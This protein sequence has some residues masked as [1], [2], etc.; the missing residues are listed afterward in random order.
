[1][2]AI[3]SGLMSVIAMIVKIVLFPILWPFKFLFNRLLGFSWSTPGWLQS[4]NGK[5]RASP[6]K[7]WSSLVT[8]VILI[9]GGYT[10][11]QWYQSIPEPAQVLAQITAPDVSANTEVVH[12][13]PLDIYFKYDYSKNSVIPDGQ[14]SVARIED[15]D[16]EITK[17]I[18]LFPNKAG[19]W[20]WLGDKHI[21]F[22]PKQDWPAAQTYKVTFDQSMFA[23]SVLMSELEY[24]FTTAE[25]FVRAEN[26]RLYKDPTKKSEQRLVATLSFSHPVDKESL[27][28]HLELQIKN[29]KNATASIERQTFEIN[30]G[31]NDREA[32]IKSAPIQLPESEKYAHLVLGKEVKAAA[33][34]AKF[35]SEI[36]KKILL[37][38]ASTFLKVSQANFRILRN[39]ENKPEQILTLQFT[40]SIS[41][42]EI[43]KKLEI[44]L[45][46]KS[47]KSWNI[48]RAER[49]NLSNTKLPLTL[50]EN[51]RDFSKFYNVKLDVPEN[52]SVYIKVNS[53]LLSTSDYKLTKNYQKVFRAPDYPRETKIM[54]EGSLMSLNGDQTLS[55]MARGHKA[56]K[57]SLGKLVDHQLNHLISQTGG[58]ISSP[59]FNNYLF[60]QNNIVSNY[61]QVIRLSP[62]H[63]KE[64]NYASLP[65]TP[66]LKKQ[67]M[68]VFFVKVEG[69]N[70]KHNYREYGTEDQRLIIVTDLGVIVKKTND[71][72][73]QNVF[74][75]SLSKG[76]PV[77]NA[78]VEVLGKNGLPV[79]SGHTNDSGMVEIHDLSKLSREKAP[80]VYVVSQGKDV[81][82]L[83]FDNGYRRINYSRF[84]ISGSR[85]TGNNNSRLT[86]FVFSDRGIYRPG[87]TVKLASIVKNRN[88]KNSEGIPLEFEIKDSRNKRV[89]KKKLKLNKEGFFDIE[90]KTEA[91][92]NTGNYFASVY[93]LTKRG[94]RDYRLGGVN[95]KVEEFQPDTL[96]IATEI[97]PKQSKGWLNQPALVG[98]VTLKNLFG[99]PAQD[100]KVHGTLELTPIS[101]G[102]PE[103]RAY[104]FIDPLR[105]D[106]AQL[107][108]VTE[109]LESQTTDADGLA[110][111]SMDISQYDKGTYRL[112][113]KAEG[114]EAGGGRS[115]IASSSALVS[116]LNK[117]VGYKTDGE[118]NYLKKDQ[119]RQLS[120]IG[121]N[122]QLEK[123]NLGEVTL[124][125]I[126][127]QPISTLVMANDGTYSYQSVIKDRLQDETRMALTAKGLDMHLYTEKA[128]Q[129]QLQ[130][131]S[132]QGELLTKVDYHV[133]AAGNMAGQLEKNAELTLKLD[134]RDYKAG[135]TIEMNIIAPYSGSGLITIESDKVHN[136]KWFKTSTN[137]TVETIKV[138]A[139][140]EGNAYV[141][142]TFVRSPDSKEVF[143]SPLSY[144]VKPF[145]IDRSAREVDITL[146][147]EPLV[148]PGSPMKIGYK[149]DKPSRIVVFAVDE[150]ILQVAKYQQPKP[151]DHFLTKLALQVNT[152][153]ILDLI[154]PEYR[155]LMEQAGIGGGAESMKLLGANLN[156]FS[157]TVDKPAVYW[158]GI[159]HADATE[160]T[161]TFNVPDTFSGNLKVMAVAVSDSAMGA[162]SKDSIVR[163]PFVLSPNVLTVAAPN[164]AFDVVVGV[165]NGIEGSGDNADIKVSVK[166]SD[167]LSVVG[168][169]K[170][171][172]IIG[173]G[174]EKKARFKLI[175]KSDQ[176]GS[177]LGE[178]KV[179]FI[180]QHKNEISERS[181]TLSLRPAS[182]YATRVKTGYSEDKVELNLNPTLYSAFS[183]KTATA[184]ASPMVLTQ[185]LTE[186]L[187]NYIHGCTEQVVSKVFPWVTLSQERPEQQTETREKLNALFDKL[188]SRQTSD[189]GFGY[190]QNGRSYAFPTLYAAHL[191]TEAKLYGYSV[192]KELLD[193]ALEKVRD[194]ARTQTN[195]LRAARLRAI[196]IYL[197]TRNQIVATSYLVDIHETLQAGNSNWQQ[198]ITAVYLAASYQLLKKQDVA[199]ELVSHYQ[200]GKPAH[201]RTDFQ[202]EL[203][204]D[205]QYVYLISSHFPEQQKALDVHS[206][207][208]SLLK[209]PINGRINTISSSYTTMALSAYSQQ[210]RNQFGQDSVEFT[211][212]SKALAEHKK[213]ALNTNADF[214]E[215]DLS[216][217]S[218]ALE[219]AASHPVFYQT[220]QSGFDSKLPS[221]ANYQGLEVF[222]EYLDDEGNV[223][224]E[225]AQGQE[226]NVR[227]R[228][229]ATSGDTVT[230]TAIIDLLPGGFEIVRSSVPR[231]SG[232]WQSDYV[233]VREDRVVFY[234]QFD[235]GVTEL[236]YRVK[237]TSAGQFTV[238]AVY[239]ESMYDP[240][241]F[242]HSAAGTITVNADD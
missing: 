106:R 61:D 162:T 102:F 186:Y 131:Y 168:D 70:P 128:G 239:G 221:E 73:R 153:Q 155:I 46:P 49:A 100:R 38:D 238:P 201:E 5:R 95:F 234:G 26:F 230:N 76:L 8:L 23:E 130:M 44:H 77:S 60:D 233:D 179:T 41:V 2:F 229:R 57:V 64:L 85:N 220:I 237:A 109:T 141:N 140:L 54:G 242:G 21:R 75:Q 196:A 11:Y 42:D 13:Q 115:V 56:I 232:Y 145:N 129:Y 31:L 74:V 124:K 136:H 160:R 48:S 187:N 143:T 209:A 86:A 17:G 173:E 20:Q 10:G 68:G 51:E 152:Y 96:K 181:A 144:A 134:R 32:Y 218:S 164:D 88:F 193:R 30:Y 223:I 227:L 108:S 171:Q 111:F 16:K 47:K 43:N 241:I 199:E 18:R 89:L 52:R 82:F 9:G 34:G 53:G 225:I 35:K 154:L 224:A 133:V 170:T 118:L 120:F 27:K 161:L 3:T 119:A 93:L 104:N 148:R 189:G 165:A 99:T 107:R 156:P 228:I 231:E 121:I 81:S 146:N 206:T 200:L 113:F 159:V 183:D 101:F 7:F 92:S 125:R 55:F 110:Q 205:A 14:L 207:I 204:M 6:G 19:K 79:F 122:H 105:D 191:L 126:F 202:S 236:N 72:N 91:T 28:E 151:L 177:V 194:I 123:V 62:S 65:L 216:L 149:T 192:P 66:Y 240:A 4:L 97:T 78:K 83:P 211:D 84:D 212:I 213:L 90:L 178:A 215:V 69:W 112:N 29:T 50:L 94:Y 142:V 98:K 184:S 188:R 214:P 37:P 226:V 40:D 67:G 24:E 63:P 180:A 158:S 172:L 116:P 45:L 175:A 163:G 1:M 185:G 33:N 169:S 217:S 195:N 138:P 12:P 71:Y 87:E 203:T 197:L 235:K 137:S 222:K 15:V 59:Y 176:Q 132:E 39:E 210:N 127:K 150:G 174:S 25:F 198:D 157:R 219:I 190:W 117:L 135:D 166:V 58:D 80:T 114:F 167:N 208:M 22:V 147:T 182:S 36:N 139:G 103:F